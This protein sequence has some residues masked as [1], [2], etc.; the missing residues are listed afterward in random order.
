M[1]SLDKDRFKQTYGINDEKFLNYLGT[2]DYNTFRALCRYY[3]VNLISK[4]DMERVYNRYI[5]ISSLGID[6]KTIDDILYKFYKELIFKL[7]GKKIA[8][9]DYNNEYISF[10]GNTDNAFTFSNELVTVNFN[11][12]VLKQLT[13]PANLI[14]NL[15]IAENITTGKF[16]SNITIGGNCNEVRLNSEGDVYFRPNLQVGTLYGTITYIYK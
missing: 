12:N 3:D 9:S 16:I 8:I 13:S 11:F 5:H 10:S 15:P 4:R 2:G 6:D 7:N 14:F 1:K